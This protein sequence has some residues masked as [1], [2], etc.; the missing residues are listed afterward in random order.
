MF[1]VWGENL[2]NQLEHGK[3][4]LFSDVTTS[5]Y[6]GQLKI[7]TTST[8]KAKEATNQL[9]LSWKD[10]GDEKIKKSCCPDVMAAKVTTYLICRNIHCKKKINDEDNVDIITCKHCN[11]AMRKSKCLKSYTVKFTILCNDKAL[12]LT[13]FPNVLDHQFGKDDPDS[14]Q[15]M[16]LNLEETYIEYDVKRNVVTNFFHHDI[17]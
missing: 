12:E 3:T 16:I 13:A 11:N 2:I 14:M 9:T 10:C 17:L 6:R 4:Y 5:V 15:N 7:V 1:S 8:T